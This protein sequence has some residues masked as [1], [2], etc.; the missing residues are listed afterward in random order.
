MRYEVSEEVEAAV[1]E[2]AAETEAQQGGQRHQL[3][4]MLSRIFRAYWKLV[5]EPEDAKEREDNQKYSAP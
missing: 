4:K 5:R 1:E 3:M 2:G